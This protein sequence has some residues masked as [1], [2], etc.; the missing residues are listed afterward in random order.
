MPLDDNTGPARRDVN[1][2]ERA[3]IR[4]KENGD[5]KAAVFDF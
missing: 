4:A 1:R 3:S 2:D 5:P